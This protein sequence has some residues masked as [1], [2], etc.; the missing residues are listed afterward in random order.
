VRMPNAELADEVI[1]KFDQAYR[2]NV[3]QNVRL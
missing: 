2:E 1:E 3:R